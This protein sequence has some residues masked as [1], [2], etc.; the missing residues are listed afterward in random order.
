MTFHAIGFERKF[1]MRMK[2]QTGESGQYR[3]RARVKG[4]GMGLGGGGGSRGFDA[5]S[6]YAKGT[7]GVPKIKD[8]SGESKCERY[9]GEVR[10]VGRKANR[11]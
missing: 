3:R 10:E 8:A 6:G 1:E 9:T 2:K 5:R 11:G 4:M 7:W